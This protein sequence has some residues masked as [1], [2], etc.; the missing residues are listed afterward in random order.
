MKSPLRTLLLSALLCVSSAAVADSHVSPDP[1]VEKA[2][3]LYSTGRFEQALG[4]LGSLDADHPDRTDV[5]FLTGMAAIGA[6]QGREDEDEQELLLD[7]AIAAFRDILIARPDLV[8]VRLELARAFFLKGDDDLAREHFERVLAGRPH[9]VVV[10]NVQRF[11]R[12][13]PGPQALELPAPV[14]RLRPDSNLGATSE[15]DVIYIYDL[16][17]KRDGDTDA[18]SGIGANPVGRGGVPVSAG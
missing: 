14:S 13:D 6:A 5:L 17:F 7:G 9:P 3:T 2:R 12:P 8:R 4:I 1:A 18:R 15:D 16:P 10:A 11:P